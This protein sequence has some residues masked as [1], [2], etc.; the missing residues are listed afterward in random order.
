[1]S[2]RTDSS[3]SPRRARPGWRRRGSRSP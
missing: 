2:P 3:S 1:M